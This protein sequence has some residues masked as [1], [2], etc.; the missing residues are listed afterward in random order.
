MTL[1]SILPLL[2][3]CEY[4]AKTQRLWEM[5]DH[6]TALYEAGHAIQHGNLAGLRAA[7]TSLSRPDGTNGA[8]PSPR[9]CCLGVGEPQ[10]NTSI[11][12][13]R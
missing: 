13:R 9:P 5:V 7:G 11:G 4:R 12:I 2:G 6:E 8:R 3:A 10:P 1:L